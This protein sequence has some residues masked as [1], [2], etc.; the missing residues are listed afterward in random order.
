V[1][2]AY[3]AYSIRA[4]IL[5]IL[6]ALALAYAVNP[7]ITWAQRRFRMPRALSTGIV[8]L[9][10]AMLVGGLLWYLLPR[11]TNQAAGLVNN[12]P[13]YVERAN[14]VAKD[15]L[16]QFHQ[17]VR[18]QL[19]MAPAASTTAPATA[20]APAG[21]T[22]AGA[23]DAAASVPVDTAQVLLF[24][25]KAL[26][27]TLLFVVG[28]VG[29]AT[30]VLLATLVMSFCFFCFSWRFDRILAWFDRFIPPANRPR[31]LQVL[32]RMDRAVSAFI[33]GRLV[34]ATVVAT[35]LSVGWTF[36]GVPYALLLGLVCGT[37]NLVP[38]AGV[39][40]WPIAVL[41]TW[42]DRGTGAGVWTVLVWPSV[43]Y[44]L[45]VFIDAWIVEPQVQGR[46][47]DLDPL[48]VLL[49]VLIGGSLAGI[50]GLML[51]VPTA[52]CV[53]ILWQEVVGGHV[54][55]YLAKFSPPPPP[56]R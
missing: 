43:V 27:L 37:L 42:V 31:V 11:L 44:G 38:Y 48:T 34:Q 29:L 47:A 21:E 22:G 19:S 5:P 32:K 17:W 1:L 6:I 51:A 16:P 35:V 10:V 49:A 23:A 15:R 50:L 12:V 54:R 7:L 52:A 8:M 55:D 40:G 39:V 24:F 36:A 28:A 18:K 45:A 41:L 20:P 14:Q 46:A 56:P 53:K 4:V 3:L 25:Y 2:L 9:T 26:G 33:R 13:T 30:Y